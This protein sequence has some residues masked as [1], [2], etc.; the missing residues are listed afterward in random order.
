LQ[1]VGRIFAQENDMPFISTNINPH[2]VSIDQARAIALD[3]IRPY[4]ERGDTLEQIT[5]GG[6]GWAENNCYAQIGG[7]RRAFDKT[8]HF[9]RYRIIVTQIDDKECIIQFDVA[10]LIAEIKQHVKQAR[11]F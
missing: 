11:L 10:E 7:T 8:Y 1:G 4:V 2:Q 3:N 5:E 9:N 6:M